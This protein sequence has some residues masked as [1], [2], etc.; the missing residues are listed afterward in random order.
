MTIDHLTRSLVIGTA[1]H[2]DHGKSALV[3]AL[4]GTDP[5]RLKEERARGITI[6]LGF[7]HVALGDLQ[8][9]FVDV[10]GHE[11]FVRN[12]LAGAGGLDAVLLVVAADESVMPQ[13]REHFDICRLLGIDRGAIVL[14]KSDLVDADTVEL[15]ALEVRE[16]VAGSFL[17]GAAVV[18]VSAKSGAGLDALRAAITAL[19]G[20]PLRQARPGVTR[21]PVD[22]V[23]SVRGFGT[24]VTGTLVSG[25]V[26]EGDEVVVL[27]LGRTARVRGIQTHGR[28][29]PAVEAPA[30][31]AINLGA[32]DVGE[33]GRGVTLSTPEALAMTRRVDVR[34]SL[35]RSARALPH[36][37][38][39]RLHHGTSELLGRV[40]VSAVR[41]PGLADWRRV[42]VGERAVAVPAGADAFVRLRLDRPAVLTRGDRVVIR[43][44]SPPTTIGG[45]LVLDPEPPSGGVRRATTFERF[46]A[47]DLES[48][49]PEPTPSARFARVWLREAGLRGVAVADLVRRGGLG[50][51]E[52]VRLA[53]SLCDAAQAIASNGRL[54][55]VARVAQVE[56]RLA[57]ELDQF[58][59]QHPTEPGM[60]REALRDLAAPGAPP[61]VFDAIVAQL[62][63]RGKL[64]GT[65][66]LALPARGSTIDA[67]TARRRDRIETLIRGGG[68][69]PPDAAALQA[70]AGLSAAVIDQLVHLLVR[71]RRVLRL[72]SVLFHADVLA[73]LREDIRALK[74][75]VPAS[76]PAQVDVAAFKERYGLSRKFAIPLME[77]LDRER[78]TR[79]VGEGRLIL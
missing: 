25:A 76:R 56:T 17:E 64:T 49:E 51:A 40:A 12:M 28:Q 46:R 29:V 30:R 4:T 3:K 13:T 71:D 41:E 24:V 23:F 67:E 5:D 42:E 11:R 32:I 58:H 18:P 15:V 39:V 22:R 74:R 68:L 72:G 21:L 70:A 63:S 79:R 52:A 8:V 53:D 61:D 77:W 2:I 55:D 10:P 33:L 1:G 45:G 36:G 37:A 73:Q 26:R 66:R 47:L 50:S 38:R 7:A 43:A 59:D 35:V 75:D 19:A 60:P 44:Y 14:T 9:A 20:G 78:V 16:L 65:D 34:L 54:F 31:A 69:A 62:T 57:Q 48:A 27:P 6:D